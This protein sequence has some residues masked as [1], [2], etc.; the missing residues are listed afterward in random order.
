MKA[1]HWSQPPPDASSRPPQLRVYCGS[2]TIVGDNVI[3]VVGGVRV[4]YFNLRDSRW[5][6]KD[7][8]SELRVPSFDDEEHKV[9]HSRA[10]VSRAGHT[11]ARFGFSIYM[12]GGD[13]RSRNVYEY[14]P[15][16]DLLG[17]D[18]TPRA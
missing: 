17:Y 10:P 8:N 5:R 9:T 15:V 7:F 18:C 13:L 16:L 11:M 3:L 2:P 6:F 14:M 4:V 1:M 12:V